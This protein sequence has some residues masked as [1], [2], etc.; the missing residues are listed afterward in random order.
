MIAAEKLLRIT[1]FSDELP[2][3]TDDDL[4]I[5]TE[6][7]LKSRRKKLAGT[8]RAF[9][10]KG[11]IPVF[12]STLWFLLAMAISIELAFGDRATNKAAHD[13]ALGLL[14]A[15]LPIFIM[16][17]RHLSRLWLPVRD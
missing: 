12:V 16:S 15:F 17:V 10:K 6:D 11:A 1:L 2:M 3:T 13:L 8:I 9:R 14:L 4:Q 7:S 5:S